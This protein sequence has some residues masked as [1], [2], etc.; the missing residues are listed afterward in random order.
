MS[1]MSPYSMPL[2]T[3]F[4]KLPAPPG[5]TYV[6]QGPLSVCAHTFF[7]TSSTASKA[8]RCPPG[9]M[10]G[11]LRAPS[12]PPLTPMPMYSSPPSAT[13]LARRSVFSYHSLPPSMMMSPGSMCLRSP[14]MVSS[15]GE[16]ALTRMITQRG[17]CRLATNSPMSL[18]PVSLSP[19]PSLTA[20]DTQLSVLSPER[21]N[22]EMGKPFS[23]TLSARFCPMTASPHSPM[24]DL[25]AAAA[26]SAAMALT[27][28]EPAVLA[29]GLTAARLRDAEEENPAMRFTAANDAA[30]AAIFVISFVRGR[31]RATQTKSLYPI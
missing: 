29:A 2:C 12:S 13:A 1:C 9:I 30:E 25:G 6:T 28:R 21:L 11:P 14:A 20:R 15:T 8:A 26:A 7:S 3:I 22:T 24:R 4:T 19:R 18:Y 5:P 31:K 27:R 17:F 16:P 10:D 23:A